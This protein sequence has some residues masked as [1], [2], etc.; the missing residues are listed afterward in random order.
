MCS[1]YRLSS[2][3]PACGCQKGTP[4][5]IDTLHLAVLRYIVRVALYSDSWIH[6]VTRVVT[7][8]RI[9]IVAT[10]YTSDLVSQLNFLSF[11]SLNFHLDLGRAVRTVRSGAGFQKITAIADMRKTKRRLFHGFEDANGIDSGHSRRK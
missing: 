11:L 6:P 4:L 1:P 10:T 5:A 9:K 7:S 8:Y 2:T 3:Y